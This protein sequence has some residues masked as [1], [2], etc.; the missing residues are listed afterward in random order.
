MGHLIESSG[1]GDL[2]QRISLEQNYARVRELAE[3]PEL[4]SWLEASGLTLDEAATIQ[5]AYCGTPAHNCVCADV[6]YQGLLQGTLGDGGSTLAVTAVYGSVQGVSVGDLVPLQDNQ[7]IASSANIV[8]ASWS[9]GGGTAFAEYVV[10]SSSG[11]VVEVPITSC[12]FPQYASI[13]GPV[14]LQTF[15]QAISAPSELD[16]EQV[17]TQVDPRWGEMQGEPS[18]FPAGTGGAATGAGG[19]STAS[20]GVASGVAGSGHADAAGRCGVAAH[21]TTGSGVAIALSAAA[22]LHGARRRARASR[23]R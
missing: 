13:P 4:V 15:I 11:G 10:P 8:F 20:G 22:V 2:V 12:W 23:R 18:C 21:A 17:L 7:G 6:S 9:E 3:L 14:A 16:C 19:A 5:P 1:G